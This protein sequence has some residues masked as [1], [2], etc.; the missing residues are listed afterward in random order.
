MRTH[1]H[2]TEPG[3]ILAE[4]LA[5]GKQEMGSVNRCLSRP[6]TA[7]NRPRSGH[8]ASPARRPSDAVRGTRRAV[9]GQGLP[10]CP[11]GAGGG[12]LLVEGGLRNPA[13]GWGGGGGYW[14]GT[15]A[16]VEH[17]G[18]CDV[19]IA[20]TFDPGWQAGID[21]GRAPPIFPVDGGFLAVRLDGLGVDRVAMRYRPPGL[22]L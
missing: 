7:A 21:E 6:D 1:F 13:W 3:V 12:G 18:P 11:G 16:T 20:R 9:Q 2:V 15:A 4:I 5:H 8:T 19:V 14:D 22:A 10:I 17:D